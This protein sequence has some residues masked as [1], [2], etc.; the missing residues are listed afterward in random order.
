MMHRTVVLGPEYDPSTQSAFAE[1]IKQLGGIE[2]DRSW[3][4]GGSQEV[5]TRNISFPNGTI[6]IEEETY[7]GLKISGDE[8]IVEQVAAY[9]KRAAG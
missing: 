8:E 3:G 1:A 6:H 4:I 5:T 2:S 9:M 7:M